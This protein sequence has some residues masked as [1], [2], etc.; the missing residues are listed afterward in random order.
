MTKILF[1]HAEFAYLMMWCI[2]VILLHFFC[3]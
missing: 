1:S 2:I 3:T